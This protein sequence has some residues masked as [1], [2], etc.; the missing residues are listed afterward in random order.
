MVKVDD[1]FLADLFIPE[2]III[3]AKL[4]TCFNIFDIGFFAYYLGILI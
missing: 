3:K 2:I 1:F 4:N